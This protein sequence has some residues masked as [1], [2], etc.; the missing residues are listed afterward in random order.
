VAGTA[1][2]SLTVPAAVAGVR[3]ST[4]P[5]P[6][7]LPSSPALLV[8]GP[9]AAAPAR[10][11]FGDRPAVKLPVDVRAAAALAE[12]AERAPASRA[13]RPALRLAAHRAAARP[14]VRKLTPAQQRAA[15]AAAVRV[16]VVSFARS[17]VGARYG[18]SRGRYDCSKLVQSAYGSAGVRLPRQSGAIARRT[19][20]ISWASARPGDVIVGRG[21]VGIYMGKRKGRHMMIDAGN[22][23]VG[24]SYRPVYFNYQGLHPER[25]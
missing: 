19:R 20:A 23:R 6:A 24:V 9:A 22:R 18:T 16:R 25:V 13:G 8:S 10:Q 12:R 11:G 21:H 17:K 3:W 14:V 7:S 1:V 4:T 2:L 5:P 15:R